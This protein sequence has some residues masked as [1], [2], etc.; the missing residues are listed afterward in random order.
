MHKRYELMPSTAQPFPLFIESIGH[1]EDQ[2]KLLRPEGFPS[3][4]WLQTY[5]GEGEFTMDGKKFR[6]TKGSGVL[7]LPDVPH[8]YWAVTEQWCTQYVTF[9][10][11]CADAILRSFDLMES[12]IFRWDEEGPLQV[13]IGRILANMDAALEYSGYEASADLYHF[14]MQ[15]KKHGQINNRASI[16]NQM[17]QLQPLLN[18]LESHYDNPDIGLEEMAGILVITPRHMNTLFQHAFGLSPY[19]YL[20]MLRLRKSKEMLLKQQNQTVKDVAAQVG[21]RDTSHFVA[22]FR[23]HVGLTPERFRQMN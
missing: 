20:I 8:S 16:R 19:S 9:G 17:V 2:E 5:S 12:A 1:H 6:L 15:L 21:F 18:W 23:K 7:L 4:H 3:Y 14:L 11:T 10:G 22:S 13:E